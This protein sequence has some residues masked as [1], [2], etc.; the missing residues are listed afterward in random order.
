M[1]IFGRW[2]F[3]W[4]QGGE[5]VGEDESRRVLGVLNAAGSLV[6]GAQVAA[7]IVG[8]APVWRPFLQLAL[9]RPFGSLGRDQQPLARQGIVTPV[10]LVR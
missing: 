6:A 4:Q 5:I 9:P 7:R 8:W 3:V 1:A 2:R 10:R